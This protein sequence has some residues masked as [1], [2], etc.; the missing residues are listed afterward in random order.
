M[1]GLI[2]RPPR[3]RYELAKLGPRSFRFENPYVSLYEADARRRGDDP[4]PG[5]RSLRGRSSFYARRGVGGVE[6]AA[7]A[8][9]AA[10]VAVERSEF[11]TTNARGLRVDYSW[12]KQASGGGS[13]AASAPALLYLHGNASCRVEALQVLTLCLSLGVTLVALDCAGSG[14]SQG[15]GAGVLRAPRSVRS[16]WRG[17]AKARRL[18]WEAE[19]CLATPPRRTFVEASTSR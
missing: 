12:W 19:C 4:T 5:L 16:R 2:I 18:N 6:G 11:S 3:A 9:A 8:A 7:A 15:E 17:G 10:G 14:K 1:L 13:A